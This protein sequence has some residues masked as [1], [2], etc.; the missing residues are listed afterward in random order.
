M[1][2]R[3]IQEKRDGP[4]MM[5][6]NPFD[7]HPQFDPPKEYLDRYNP[8][9]IPYPLFRESDIGRQKQFYNIDQQTIEAVNPYENDKDV[10][11]NAKKLYGDDNIDY[12]SVPPKNYDSRKIIAAYYAMVELIDYQFGR[13]IDFLDSVGEL[14]NTIIIFMGDHGLLY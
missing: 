11:V 10:I 8:D 3:F 14:E 2:I 13:L 9:E 4:W 7:P 1:A 5:S 6:I 12:H